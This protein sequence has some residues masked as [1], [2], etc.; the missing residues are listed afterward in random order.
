M[1]CSNKNRTIFQALLAAVKENDTMEKER[2]KELLAENKEV[3]DEFLDE[4][5]I[6]DKK[7]VRM[8]SREICFPLCRT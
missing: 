5:V 8:L 7:D 3:L 1:S 2:L 6:A 4:S